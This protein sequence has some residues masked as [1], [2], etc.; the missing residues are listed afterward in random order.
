M[1]YPNLTIQLGLV[2][3]IVS[4]NSEKVTHNESAMRCMLAIPIL[5]KSAANFIDIDQSEMTEAYG[6]ISVC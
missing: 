2:Y 4:L 1:K 3:K 6:V 5:K